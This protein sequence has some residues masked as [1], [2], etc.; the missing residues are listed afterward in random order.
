MLRVAFFPGRVQTFCA[1][2]GNRAL[3]SAQL[4]LLFYCFTP[5]P[6]RAKRPATANSTH[7]SL[8]I[9]HYSLLITHY[10]LLITH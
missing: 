1:V 7:Y 2:S 9:T 3:N 10:S 5:D 6:A 4:I 8:V